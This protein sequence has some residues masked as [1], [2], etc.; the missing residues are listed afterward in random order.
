MME[1][2]LWVIFTKIV[3][4]V[5]IICHY[6]IDGYYWWLLL[7][8][9]DYYWLLMMI[10]CYCNKTNCSSSIYKVIRP[11]LNFFFFYDMISQALKS[12]KK[13]QKAPKHTKKYENALKSTTNLRFINL[14][15]L[16]Q[17]LSIR[18]KFI[19]LKRHLSG[20]K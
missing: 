8:I 2:V 7:M 10:I 16:T 6:F 19:K 18:H 13:H 5:V 11:V 17:D 9:D 1:F 14:N 3:S 12:T 4:K 20:K 15:S